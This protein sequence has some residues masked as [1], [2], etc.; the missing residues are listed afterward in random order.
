MTPRTLPRLAR[1]L[2][3]LHPLQVLA[4]PPQLALARLVRR[5]PSTAPP[6]LRDRWPDPPIA[7]TALVDAERARARARIDRLPNPSLLREFERAYALDLDLDDPLPNWN[8]PVALHPAPASQR[9]RALAVLARLG[10]RDLAPEIARAA[11]AVAL[12][13]ELHLLGNHL[14]D[15]GIGL[16][17]AAAVT[18]GP[19]S[20]LWRR[21]GAAITDWQLPRQF[22]PDGGHA[23]GSATYHLSL[24]ANLLELIELSHAAGIATPTSYVTAARRALAWVAAV[25]APDGT[26]PMFNDAALD[27]A[28]AADAVLA[29]GR[30]LGL[31]DPATPPPRVTRLHDTG[32]VIARVGRACL[33]LKAGPDG[34]PEQPG[35]VHADA[36]SFELWVDGAR[37]VVDPGVASYVDDADRRWCRGTAAHNTVQVDGEDTSEVWGAFR[38]GRRCAARVLSLRDDGDTVTVT[39]THD[40]YD[41]LPGRP[42][43]T[44]A[45]TLRDG[46][47]TVTD[48]VDGDFARAV[49]RL[50]LDAEA[51]RWVR[52]EGDALTVTEGERWFPAHGAARPAV[53]YAR[54]VPRAEDVTVTVR[55]GPSA[56]V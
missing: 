46:S 12:R 54:P 41:H 35:H 53:V 48:R 30:A 21:L 7:L 43:H 40:G 25:R 24:T 29:L 27:A 31:Y 32:W 5:V 51:A 2:A 3:R 36:L 26:V 28:P 52:V 10:R 44:R 39:A 18:R 42:R 8:A 16:L 15:N 13:P 45:L 55:W 20:S 11:R 37:A 23:E 4:R 19:E 34:D 17:A 22:L 38:V 33:A 9:A 1:T 56:A 47:L 50:R 14:L 6:T 49:A